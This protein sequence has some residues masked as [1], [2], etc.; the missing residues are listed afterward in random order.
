MK[1]NLLLSV[2]SLSFTYPDTENVIS[3]LCLSMKRGEK[4][5]LIGPNGSGKTTLF[6]LLCGILK[7]LTGT[8]TVVGNPIEY[9]SFNP[10]I[11]YLFQSPDDQLFSSTV[12]D[13]VAFGPLNMEIPAGEVD[14]RSLAALSA[15]GCGHLAERPSHHLSGGEKRLVA[16]ATILSMDPQ[17]LLLDE[18][19]SNLDGR[20]R[21]KVIEIINK[22]DTSLFIASHDMEFL[23]ETCERVILMD[24]GGIILDGAIRDVLADEEV[25]SRHGIEKPHSLTS[26]TGTNHKHGC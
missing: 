9:G 23:L 18:P 10:S 3:E 15:V 17:I 25:L 1:D 8:I 4:T 6:M 22:I 12:L 11:S 26:H 2:E 13:D 21:R 7:P 14:R 16:I 5:A 19:V 24:G 20:N